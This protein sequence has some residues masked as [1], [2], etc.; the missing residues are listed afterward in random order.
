MKK[1]I[2]ID[3]DVVTVTV[4]DKQGLNVQRALDF[5]QRVKKREFFVITPFFLLE[6]VSKWKHSR[7]KD[8]IENFYI[9]NTDRMLTNVDI[10]EKIESMS[11]DDYSLLEKLRHIGIKGEDSLLALAASIFDAEYLV[12]F[13]RIHLKRNKDKINE[14]LKENGLRTIK[15]I[16]PEEA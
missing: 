3:L 6:L 13:N 16:G 2:M 5:V 4:W 12:T 10:D 14:V 8:H 15:I 9:K 1:Q 11:I 7:L